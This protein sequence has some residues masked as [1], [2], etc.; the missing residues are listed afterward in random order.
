M[1]MQVQIPPPPAGSATAEVDMTVRVRFQF[2]ITPFVALQTI[3][4]YLLMNVG[5]MV[6]ADEPTTMLLDKGAFWRVPVFCAYPDLGHRE[7]LGDLLVDA[8]S[9]AVTLQDSSFSSPEEIADR[10]EERYRSLTTPAA[11]T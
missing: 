11:R 2:N 8:E 4:A 3:N 5:H 1:M 10:A 7:Y 9:G 6:S